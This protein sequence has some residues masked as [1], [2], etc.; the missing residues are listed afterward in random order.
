MKHFIN[1]KILLYFPQRNRIMD[2]W[3]NFHFIDELSRHDVLFE[4]Y[5][6]FDFP[7]KSK[8]QMEEEMLKKIKSGKG[9][10]SMFMTSV[11]D[12]EISPYFLTEL[13]ALRIPSLL[14]CYDNL[15]VPFRHKR[16]SK[17]FDLVWLT[18]V[19]TK[20]LF[21]RWGAKTIFLP[22][23]A[24]P[25]IFK[26]SS[27]EEIPYIGFIG[28]LYGARFKKINS[29]LKANLPVRIYN[30][31]ETIQPE[32]TNLDKFFR[33]L[34]YSINHLS[35]LTS[36]K[37]GRKCILGGIRKLLFSEKYAFIQNNEKNLILPSP[38]FREMP[39]IY[40]R[41]SISLNVSELWD[42]YTLVTPIHKLHLRT[43]EIPMSGGLQIISE[44]K[45]IKSYFEPD[46]EIILYG[47]DDDFIEKLKFYLAP[48]N[49]R[50]RCKI[51]ANAKKR[52][53]LEHTWY[54]RFQAIHDNLFS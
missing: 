10:Y 30:N 34:V 46:K 38:S 9:S 39:S 17:Y 47:D 44:T 3:Q 16:I 45:E 1:K 37:I 28:T 14:I 52:A 24:N 22:Y 23:A 51:K 5:N 25:N 41:L 21:D 6:P 54:N 20:Y 33:N 40:S 31:S 49:S 42:T 35:G 43:F 11:K 36:F 53:E 48:H 50:L 13:K 26:P 7:E 32:P 15:S 12:G 8:E 4:I 19:E 2:A 29:L 27:G 18:S